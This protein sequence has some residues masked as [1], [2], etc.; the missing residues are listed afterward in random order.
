MHRS[1]YGTDSELLSCCWWPAGA[2]AIDELAAEAAQRAT[3]LR[4]LT[5]KGARLRKKKALTDFLD[6]LQAAGASRFASAVPL[7]DRSVHAWFAQ[8]RCSLGN[9]AAHLACAQISVQESHGCA[10]VICLTVHCS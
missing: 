7:H 9:S 2:Q 8:V 10:G 1:S 5:A 4:T 6:A 3:E